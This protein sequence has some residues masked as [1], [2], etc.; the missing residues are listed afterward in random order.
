MARLC[1]VKERVHRGL[2][3]G[4]HGATSQKR[5]HC[6]GEADELQLPDISKK[7]QLQKRED[8]LPFQP[9][10]LVLCGSNLVSDLSEVST[11]GRKWWR[12]SVGSCG[13][14][15]PQDFREL[16]G[17]FM[18][19]LR[20]R[21]P[22]RRGSGRGSR[23]GSSSRHPAENEHHH[24]C[25]CYCYRRARARPLQIGQFTEVGSSSEGEP[26]LPAFG[27][28]VFT[29]G[30]SKSIEGINA[31]LSVLFTAAPEGDDS[32]T[33]SGMGDPPTDSIG[34]ESPAP[35]P[36]ITHGKEI[37]ETPLQ[38]QAQKPQDT[39]EARWAA[40]WEGVPE[41]MGWRTIVEETSPGD[42]DLEGDGIDDK[43]LGGEGL[44]GK[45]LGGEGSG[46]DGLGG[47]G[48]GDKRLGND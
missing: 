29:L 15:S 5:N 8:P 42:G 23:R 17:G 28:V 19:R 21:Q 38:P 20:E 37:M 9:V 12:V 41:G 7:L 43:G 34:L 6:E 44:G 45:C 2:A 26:A 3:T 14:N 11:F 18:A 33:P 47:D 39:A 13:H 32:R 46:G 27:S 30:G 31:H 16:G 10:F 48:L 40:M 1:A 24:C 4:I 36:S 25:C 35:Q 22:F